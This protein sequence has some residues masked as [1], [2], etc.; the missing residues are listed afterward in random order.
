MKKN[1]TVPICPWDKIEENLSKLANVE[2]LIIYSTSSQ[3]RHPKV[4]YQKR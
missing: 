1:I 3:N 2:K 4:A